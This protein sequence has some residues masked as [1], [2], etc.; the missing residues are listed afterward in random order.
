MK[1]LYLIRHAKSSWSIDGIE[2]RDRPLKGRGIRDAHLVSQFLRDD[3]V[4]SDSIALHTSP[5]T[6]ALHT[7]LIFAKNLGVSA[8]KLV[9]DDHLYHCG[10]SEL[11]QI[12]KRTA[13]IYSSA[14]YFV[15]NPSIT[16]FVNDMTNVSIKNVPTAGVVSVRFQTEQWKDIGPGAE[17][18]LF[19]YPKRLKG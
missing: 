11:T 2:D 17:L 18:L 16:E 6:R 13:D 9:L 14:I 7:A 10:V 5:A 12:V 15:H 4:D 19:E 3:I 1:T 8:N